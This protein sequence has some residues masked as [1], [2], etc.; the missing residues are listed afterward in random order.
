MPAYNEE[1]AIPE[2]LE[3]WSGVVSRCNGT[4]AVINDGSKDNT[5]RILKDSMDKYPNLVVIDKPN[6]GHGP[7]CLTGYHWAKENGFNWVFQTDGDGQT[8][9]D[10][11][12]RVWEDRD[13]NN[14]IF[15]LRRQ[16]R[17]GF[18]RRIVSKVLQLVI[19]AVF[20]VFIPDANVP[21]RLMRV[22]ALAPF[23]E[24][25]SP[26]LFLVNTFLTV[27]IQKYSKIKWV[28]ISFSPR[29]GGMPSINW[30]GFFIIGLKTTKEFW[31]IRKGL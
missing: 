11:F 28:D 29:K 22:E 20:G 15:G 10:E 7:S 8:R 16:R 24:K 12:L 6:S 17:D 25:V 9:G 23:L 18:G 19:L 31:K 1:E 26:N 21:F 30:R 4:L 27:V 5:L 3:E 2:V 13:D 14:F